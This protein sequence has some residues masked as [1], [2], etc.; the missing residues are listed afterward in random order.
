MLIKDSE[1]K[2]W[3]NSKALRIGKEE[4]AALGLSDQQ[5][6]ITMIVENGKITILPKTKFPETLEELFAGYDG[7]ALNS[8]D[9]YEWDEPVGR[10]IL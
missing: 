7:A 3:G 1:L 10:E 9:R 5:L 6:A 8:D 4:L 2:T